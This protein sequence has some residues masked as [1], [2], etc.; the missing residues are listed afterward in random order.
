MV[1]ATAQPH[2]IVDVPAL[3]TPSTRARGA[4]T[5]GSAGARPPARTTE[6]AACRAP[7]RLRITARARRLTAAFVLLVVVVPTGW[8]FAGS[9]ADATLEPASI[10]AHPPH[11][12][13]GEGD[14]VWGLVADLAPAGVERVAWVRQVVVLNDFDPGALPVGTVVRLPQP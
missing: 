11:M 3:R 5:S 9:T 6:A 8:L 1:I 7:T 4:D 2:R 10:A 12:V 14:T 13:L